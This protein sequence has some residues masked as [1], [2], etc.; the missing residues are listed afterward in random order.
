MKTIK[1]GLI[2]AVLGYSLSGCGAQTLTNLREQELPSEK[3]VMEYIE[4]CNVEVTLSRNGYFIKCD[5]THFFDFD[6]V[7]LW[8]T[9]EESGELSWGNIIYYDDNND[10]NVDRLYTDGNI[11]NLYDAR[12]VNERYQNLLNKLERNLVDLVW[13][14]RW[15]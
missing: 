2:A 12:D 4:D 14:E 5:D 8:Y 10:G 6:Y 13:E 7:R 1:N 3:A 9:I 15:R 11:I